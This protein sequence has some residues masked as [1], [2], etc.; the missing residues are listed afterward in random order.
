MT[1][2]L[3]DSMTADELFAFWNQH[4]R[5]T[6]A[7]RIALFGQAGKGTVVAAKSLANYAANKGTAMQCRERGTIETALQYERICDKI[8]ATLPEFAK[9]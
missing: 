5:P 3:D 7:Q 1:I 9:W 4:Q 8:Y 6:K 2:N